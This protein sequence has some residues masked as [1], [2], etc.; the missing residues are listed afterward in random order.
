MCSLLVCLPALTITRA[1]P[2]ILIWRGL[3][4]LCRF[5]MRRILACARRGSIHPRVGEASCSIPRR[6][7]ESSIDIY[8]SKQYA[9]TYAHHHPPFR[10]PLAQ[11]KEAS[12]RK[13]PDADFA[14]RRRAEGRARRTAPCADCAFAPASLESLGW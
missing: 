13:R 2:A 7:G 11:G 4:G 6:S 1:F 14:D 12:G 5:A 9:L 10:R 3:F 8:M